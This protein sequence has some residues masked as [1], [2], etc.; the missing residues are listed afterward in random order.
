MSVRFYVYMSVN[1]FERAYTPR[2]YVYVY[3][4]KNKQTNKQT[5]KKQI[6]NISID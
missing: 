4:H 3:K 6:K 5:K 2:E 1:K